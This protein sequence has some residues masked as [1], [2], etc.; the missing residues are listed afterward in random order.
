MKT[1]GDVIS[2]A[3]GEAIKAFTNELTFEIGLQVQIIFLK[4]KTV[5]GK[6]AGRGHSWV[7]VSAWIQIK[8]CES[9]W[10]V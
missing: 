8:P 1:W 10:H 4:W 2:S 6:E 9:T 7:A 5:M 3:R